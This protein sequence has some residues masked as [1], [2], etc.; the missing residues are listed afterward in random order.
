MNRP[1]AVAARIAEHLAGGRIASRADLEADGFSSAGISRLLAAGVLERVG[2]RAVMLASDW[3]GDPWAPV[4]SCYGGTE[5]EPRGVVCL[6]SAAVL[7]ELT[8]LGVDQIGGVEVAVPRGMS[9]RHRGLQVRIVRWHR[10]VAFEAE[11]LEW[12]SF[13]SHGIHVTTPARTVC[14]LFSPWRPAEV[15]SRVAIEAL[16]RLLAQDPAQAERAVAFASRMGWGATMANA[17]QVAAAAVS[18]APGGPR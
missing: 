18:W 4:A 8:D 5:A 7:H 1:S 11:G 6:R 13:G 16:S 12:R 17:Y 14:D 2:T 10:D 15:E 9:H 3:E